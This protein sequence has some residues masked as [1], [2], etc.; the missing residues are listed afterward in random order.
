MLLFYDIVDSSIT[1]KSWALACL[2]SVWNL[3]KDK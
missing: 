2:I 1:N 3:N